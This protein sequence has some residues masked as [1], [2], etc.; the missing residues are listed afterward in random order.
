MRFA[1][2]FTLLS[3]GIMPFAYQTSAHA[4]DAAAPATAADVQ[5]VK[6]DVKN[7]SGDVSKIADDVKKLK[8]LKVSGFVQAQYEMNEASKEGVKN[9][10]LSASNLNQFSVRRGRVKFTYTGV[11]NTEIKFEIDATGKGVS[12]KEAEATWKAPLEAVNLTISA[13]QMKYPFGYELPYS[14]SSREL[15]ELPSVNANLFPGEYDRGIKLALGWKMLNLQ[16]GAYNGNGVEDTSGY[17]YYAK[18]TDTNA[19]GTLDEDE[20]RDLDYSNTKGPLNFS[21]NDRDSFKDIVARLGVDQKLGDKGNIS[22]GLSYYAG[23]WGIFNQAYL[24]LDGT[25]QNTNAITKGAKT[26]AGV[27]LQAKLKLVPSLGNTELR[28][29]YITGTG[30]YLKTTEKELPVA[31]Y[32]V[33]F[34]Q[35]LTSAA[36]FAIRYDSFDKDTTET[37][38][39]VSSIEPALL[40]FVTDALRL[41]AAYQIVSDFDDKD[42]AG[43]KVDK[44]NNRFLLRLQ[45]KF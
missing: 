17:L 36:Q 15:P 41:T 30:L 2:H 40:F 11:K 4:E 24:D 3:I 14:S 44:A 45:G 31:G 7:L 27:D 43:N 25:L 33:T 32:S 38:N 26:R 5:A 34:L 22:G 9:S 1:R 13:G 6:S 20:L 28:A 10:D 29:E 18:P 8:S 42:D 19:N 35:G 39:E 23:A 16:V 12:L 37:E 21:N